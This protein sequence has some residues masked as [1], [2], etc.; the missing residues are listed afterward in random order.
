[1]C[2]GHSWNCVGKYNHYWTW[3]KC[4]NGAQCSSGYKVYCCT[5][6]SPYSLIYWKGIAP[7]C[8]ASCNDCGKGDDCLIKNNCGN[9]A[10]CWSGRKVL[11]GRKGT[12]S[13]AELQELMK[14][15]EYTKAKE[16]ENLNMALLM[17]EPH[18]VVEMEGSDPGLVLAN[19]NYEK[20]VMEN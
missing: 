15:S 19:V 8:S 17:G 1:M 5:K 14:L 9:G 13:M 18:Q 12:T 20:F 3:S 4:G 6:P 11:C 16:E 7:F 2:A 10:G